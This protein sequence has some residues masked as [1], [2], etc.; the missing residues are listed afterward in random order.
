MNTILTLC[1]YDRVHLS[2]IVAE[3]HL[4][5][6]P[7]SL[8][9]SLVCQGQILSWLPANDVFCS[10]NQGCDST[11]PK[12][13]LTQGRFLWGRQ[14]GEESTL[15]GTLKDYYVN[16]KPF[17]GMNLTY[18]FPSADWEREVLL[19]GWETWLLFQTVT[20]ARNLCVVTETATT[21]FFLFVCYI[22]C[23]SSPAK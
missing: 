6:Q 18:N 3:R 5:W 14:T 17:A 11:W 1:I 19:R 20:Q 13:V 16:T 21:N 8:N 23:C 12:S 22:L 2:A 7:L 9:I 15:P 10:V 4:S